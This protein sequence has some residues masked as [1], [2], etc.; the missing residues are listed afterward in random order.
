VAFTC[1]DAAG[2]LL[3]SP[4]TILYGFATSSLTW[5]L[6]QVASTSKE[7]AGAV[8]KSQPSNRSMKGSA[9]V[10]GLE[11]EKGRPQAPAHGPAFTLLGLSTP[12]ALWSCLAA[13]SALPH[14]SVYTAVVCMQTDFSFTR[15]VVSCGA[16]V[17][18]GCCVCALP[19]P[20]LSVY[21]GCV[22]IQTGYSFTRPVISCNAASVLFHPH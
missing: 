19:P 5:V 21:C 14:W 22:K 11:Y 20:L 16:V 9:A 6:T 10:D 7:V 4:T 18:S 2:A 1:K 17:L 15:P 12:A 8:L 13:A 3:Q